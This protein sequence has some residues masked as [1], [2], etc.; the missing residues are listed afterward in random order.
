MNKKVIS[1]KYDNIEQYLSDISHYKTPTLE[2]EKELFKRYKSGDMLAREELIKRNLRYVVYI[3]K[4]YINNN[5]FIPFL[6]M[7]EEGNIGLIEAVNRFDYGLNVPF[8]SY[9]T[10]WIKKYIIAGIQD[11]SRMIKIPVN[12]HYMIYQIRKA[13]AKYTTQNGC[14]PTNAE[15]AQI[16]NMDVSTIKYYK[17]YYFDTSSLDEML[18]YSLDKDYEFSLDVGYDY[19]EN[20]HATCDEEMLDDIFYR[21]LVHDVINSYKLSSREREI[22]IHRYNLDGDGVFTAESLSKIYGISRQRIL[23]IENEALKK[24][25]CD[26]NVRKYNLSLSK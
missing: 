25:R 3:A 5:E 13:T 10:W 22:I 19:Y 2:E 11:K 24:L 8:S 23:Q 17:K 21:D 15:L 12:V 18:Q 14:E 26:R 1:G 16:L 7:I 9:A 20:E 6:D 4:M